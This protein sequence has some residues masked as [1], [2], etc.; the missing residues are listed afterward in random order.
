M[1]SADRCVGACSGVSVTL[2][3]GAV[4]RGSEVEALVRKWW[5]KGDLNPSVCLSAVLPSETTA[6]AGAVEATRG[7]GL[8]A[9]SSSFA[10]VFASRLFLRDGDRAADVAC[11][12]PA[13][14]PKLLTPSG[15]LTLSAWRN[16]VD[17]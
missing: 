17:R 13:V 12:I 7:E 5:G 15:D 2:S 3:A 10:W 11:G 1:R 8:Q 4:Q 14:L 9:A 6:S 16:L